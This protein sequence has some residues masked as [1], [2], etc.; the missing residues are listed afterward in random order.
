[1]EL[2]IMDRSGQIL[3]KLTDNTVPDTAVCWL[4]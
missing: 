3:Q 1:M 2:Y 4:K